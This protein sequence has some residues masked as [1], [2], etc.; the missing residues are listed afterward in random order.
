MSEQSSRRQFIKQATFTGIGVVISNRTWAQGNKSANDR[1]NFACIGVGGKGGSDSAD[2]AEHGNVVAICDVD[3]DTLASAGNKRFPNAK[4]YT[5]WRKMLDEMGSGI[6][7]VTVSTPDHMHAVATAAAL[8]LGKACYTQKPLAH[9]VWECRQLADLARSKKVATQM[10][11]QGTGDNSM[12]RNAA[13]VRQGALGKVT[14]VHVWT[15]R[16]IW[17]QGMELP[18]PAAVP[19]GLDWDLWLGP[20]KKRPY[21]DGYLP[22]K[23][24]GWWDF[25]TGA[26]GDMACHTVNLPY[27]ALGLR[28]PISVMAETTGT[29]KASYPKASQITFMFPA[30]K[31]RGPI[32]FVWYDGGKLPSQDLLP[33]ASYKDSGS[34]IIGDKAL[35][36][37]PGD[38]GGGGKLF[39]HSGKQIEGDNGVVPKFPESPGHFEE[40]VR[41]IKGG[42]PAMSNFP[43]YSGKLAETILLGNMA[44]WSPNKVILWD[45]H[46][47]KAKNA[48]EVAHIVKPDLLNGYSL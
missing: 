3:S 31:T 47:M 9:S 26:L 35:L 25:G 46:N 36:Y 41:A 43:E 17:P 19:A 22:F 28:D 15:N 6:D 27:M 16:P 38:Y 2:C 30:T 29:N 13:L 21:G 40:W 42:E 5:D 37:T 20:A 45:A 4:R 11:N 14:E 1:I 24:R 33:G 18:A 34:L 44:V 32:K 8:H 7:A 10:G 23:W 39:E 12:R 48:P